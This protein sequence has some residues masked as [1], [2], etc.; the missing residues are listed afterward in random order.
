MLIYCI[1]NTVNNK[2][3]IGQTVQRFGRRKVSHLFDLRHNQHNY[4]LQKDYDKYGEDVFE[5]IVLEKGFDSIEELNEAE[6]FWIG[7][8][9]SHLHGYNIHL[10]NNKPFEISEESLR[11]KDGLFRIPVCKYSLD[12]DLL[13][14]YD[15]ITEASEDVDVAVNTLVVCLQGRTKTSAGYQWR[16]LNENI[17]ELDEIKTANKRRGSTK[18]VAKYSIHGELIDTYNSPTEAADDVDRHPQMIRSSCRKIKGCDTAAG[19][20]WRYYE[21]EPKKKVSATRSKYE[22]LVKENKSRAKSVGKLDLE[23]N[24]L[25]TYPSAKIA[26]EDN[27]IYHNTIRTVANGNY[28][29][30]NVG[31][32]KWVYLEN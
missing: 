20:Q 2:C 27:D 9:S 1:E 24:L 25:E 19:F 28:Y 13:G 3:Y 5:W 11:K 31:G 7:N 15:S 14:I 12:G 23:G 32:Y 29:K 10:G 8:F 30:D 6:Q 21:D 4:K 18:K 22:K 17:D 16:Y 26:G